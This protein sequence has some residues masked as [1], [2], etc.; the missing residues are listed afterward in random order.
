[1]RQRL[2]TK[3]GPAHDLETIDMKPRHLPFLYSLLLLAGLLTACN[4]SGKDN[5]QLASVEQLLDSG[6]VDTAC[7]VL[8]GVRLNRLTTPADSAYYYLLKTQAD[9]RTNHPLVSLDDIEYS[10]RY[11]E[12]KESEKLRLSAA[13]F[14]K[15]AILYTHGSFKEG[16]LCLE[17]ARAIANQTQDAVLRHKV[18]EQL[19]LVNEE[20][21]DFRTAL[22]F[23]QK[24]IAE[25]KQAKRLDWLAHTYNNMAFIYSQLGL[26][27]S[28]AWCLRQ[29]MEL[30]PNIAEKNRPFIMNNLGSFL[31]ETDTA[32]ARKYLE[33]SLEITPT[34]PAYA[35]LGTLAAMR[36]DTAR[37]TKMWHEALIIAP[38][39]P[40]EELVLK[41]IMEFRSEQGEWREATMT[42]KRLLQLS[43]S[44][45]RARPENNVRAVQSEFEQM[46]ISHNYE[47]MVTIAI[48]V[49]VV[50][51]LL[52][53]I[54]T[55]YSW[56]RNYKG[57][58]AR[59]V[60]QLLIKSYET[61]LNEL[62]RMAGDK[63]KEIEQLTRK[64]DLLMEKHRDSLKFGLQRYNEAMA[65]QTTVLWKK[66]DFESFASYYS[67]VD[68]EYVAS[69]D[70]EYD[71]LS[72]KQKFFLIMEHMDK[73]ETEIQNALGV[74]EVTMRSIRS[75]IG[76]KHK[77]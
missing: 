47:R 16:V 25:S 48:I 49:I 54:A 17:R 15:S 37:A 14:Y 35:C 41:A 72:P 32:M 30:L 11:Y 13:L 58:A 61:Q 22:R 6:R 56:Y 12:G 23:S 60:D 10:I 7:A 68:V 33:E 45:S 29:S 38:D 59:A 69:L 26:Q 67:L 2:E 19:T 43:D 8:D 52:T 9:Y 4:P 31:M 24:S 77:A 75:R 42:A 53:I 36:G 50:L 71:G 1:M 64:R 51:V 44:V 39:T 46:R 3:Q 63:T 66:H 5:Q 65:G 34:S 27:D 76:K 55:L 21:G 74:A 20:A 57:R 40:S 73:S 62:K 18:Y 70:A 28:T